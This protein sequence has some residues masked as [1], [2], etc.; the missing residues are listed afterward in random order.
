MSTP[1]TSKYDRYTAAKRLRQTLYAM[2]SGGASIPKTQMSP[3]SKEMYC[4]YTDHIESRLDRIDESLFAL[5]ADVKAR[6]VKD[7]INKIGVIRSNLRSVRMQ[8]ASLKLRVGETP[9]VNNSG[10]QDQLHQLYE[11][12][13]CLPTVSDIPETDAENTLR[14]IIALLRNHRWPGS[15][16]LTQNPEGGETNGQAEIL[17]DLA[18]KLGAAVPVGD[19]VGSTYDDGDEDGD[20][21][22]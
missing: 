13:Q 22:E 4:S 11:L 5:E 8:N 10:L 14:A 15:E 17:S 20:E 7:P 1:V 12:A 18:G 19:P 16:N 21:D 2:Y 9:L 6:K 3:Q